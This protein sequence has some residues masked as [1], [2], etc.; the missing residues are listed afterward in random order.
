MSRIRL[1]EF[2]LLPS[3]RM[4]L[5]AGSPLELGGR[6]FD[7]LLVLVENVGRL[8]SK[9]TLIERV[10]PRLV[11]DENNLPA[12]IANLRR[13]LGAG[14]IQTVPGFGYRLELSVATD[15]PNSPGELAARHEPLV[16]RRAWPIQLAPLAGREHELT[17]LREALRSSRLVTLVGIGGVGKTRLAQEILTTEPDGVAVWVPIGDVQEVQHVPSAIALAVGVSL[18]AELD[19][20]TALAQAL[21]GEPLLLI[22]DCVEHLGTLLASGLSVL[23]TQTRAVRT[24]VT[25]QAPL[26]I[27]GE[28]VYRLAALPVP[29]RDASCE[30]ASR[31]AAVMLFAQRA[32]AAD[33]R[34]ALTSAN[35][36]LVAEVVRRLDGLPLA[37]E[38]AAARIPALGLA[39]LLVHLDDRFRLLRRASASD[40]RHSALHAAF[41]WSYGLLDPHE[42]HALRRLSVFPGSFPLG[43][44]ARCVADTSNGSSD[45]VEVIA[46]LVDRSLVSVLSGDPPRY[47]LLETL[48]HF[49]RAKLHA[50]GG[51]DQAQECMAR[52]MLEL[53]DLAYRE[54][55]SLDEALWLQRFGPELENLRAALHWAIEHNAELAVSLF[56]SAW[57]LWLEADLCGEG[58]E[59][60][61]EVLALLSDA[62]PR[63][64]VGRFWE[65]IAVC[66]STRQCDRARYAA[67]LAARMHAHSGD[68][69]AQYHALMLLALNWRTDSSV[70]RESFGSARRLE[71]PTW[72]ARLLAHG[73]IAEGALLTGAERYSEARVAYER[74][75]RVALTTGE[76]QALAAT[77]GVVELDIAC[78]RTGEALQLARPLV[79]S[80]RHVGRRETLFEVLVLTF[81]AELIGGELEEAQAHGEELYALARRS[82]MAKLYLALDAMAFLACQKGRLTNAARIAACAEEASA[83]HGQI[84]RRPAE[85]RM[86]SYVRAVL[87]Q[88]LG[89]E[90]ESSAGAEPID[91]LSACSLALNI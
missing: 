9:T 2:E 4:L 32:V 83:V 72:P 67:E 41:D 62:F 47:M 69:R 18:P 50:L 63:H 56:G 85:E 13:V 8:V 28:V 3:E 71:D 23:L 66:D 82:E 40:P 53:L 64:R 30:D 84:R 43:A 33:R 74:A 7:L 27:A 14:A 87:D 20:F 68:L 19:G 11:V 15:A 48:R 6:A 80:L 88:G 46:G 25:S 78:G 10:W 73:A 76:R 35:T 61:H 37:L 59:H 70:A 58:R 29:A 89:P 21:E 86:R 1:G 91:E 81:S 49:A 54:Y 17:E 34:F 60:Y 26:G 42:Q 75:V 77:V 39:S 79:A 55:W 65:A 45:E 57:P 31:F 5:S 38:L 22:L 24:L 16:P 90:W 52:S 12:Q 36:T 44:A 51:W